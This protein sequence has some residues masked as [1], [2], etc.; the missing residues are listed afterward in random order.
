MDLLPSLP[1]FAPL[2]ADQVRDLLIQRERLLPLM[3]EGRPKRG[4][5]DKLAR[6]EQR[7][8]LAL[9][10][11]LSEIAPARQQVYDL[12]DS[13]VRAGQLSR[14]ALLDILY[15]APL[16][17]YPERLNEWVRE[18]FLWFDQ[19]GNLAPHPT[20][21]ILLQRELD[22]RKRKLP[23]PRSAPRSFFCW[24]LEGPEKPPIPYELPLVRVHEESRHPVYAMQAEPGRSL[25]LLQT[26]WKGVA[27]D[28]ENWLVYDR[29]A[30]RWVG[31]PTEDALAD[32]LS[33][34]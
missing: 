13:L 10:G 8:R 12:L 25:F 16:T 20:A 22:P 31:E 30:L 7:Q 5:P 14:R 18:K 34:Q 4:V 15:P 32:W 1:A 28:D 11:L 9:E 33:S 27:W 29:G 19:L 6:E 17:P 21:A 24:R 2:A 26:A 3:N 23:A